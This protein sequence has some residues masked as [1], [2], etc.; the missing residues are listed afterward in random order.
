[1][2]C[3]EQY[4]HGCGF[5]GQERQ[6]VAEPNQ[7]LVVAGPGERDDLAAI[8]IIAVVAER[9]ARPVERPAVASLTSPFLTVPPSSTAR[10]ARWCRAPSRAASRGAAVV[11]FCAAIA[12]LRPCPL[13]RARATAVVVSPPPA[14]AAREF[15]LEFCVSRRSPPAAA[16]SALNDRT[17][18]VE[19]CVGLRAPRGPHAAHRSPAAEC[20]HRGRVCRRHTA[21][22]V[23]EFCPRLRRCD[24][25]AYSRSAVESDPQV[26]ADRRASQNAPVLKR[27]NAVPC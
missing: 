24:A 27:W 26:A 10:T 23:L 4:R 21:E 9:A 13:V 14:A 15:G 3:A 8:E 19:F 11:R 22:D 16:A 17:P 6:H 5:F 25:A 1:M 7:L 2:N 20:E 12:V 18:L